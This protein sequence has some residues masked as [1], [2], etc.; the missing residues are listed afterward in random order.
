MIINQQFYSYRSC[1][2]IY[3][4]WIVSYIWSLNLVSFLF[5]DVQYILLFTSWQKFL[6]T[7]GFPPLICIDRFYLTFYWILYMFFIQCMIDGGFNLVI[8]LCSNN[9]CIWRYYGVLQLFCHLKVVCPSSSY[10]L[11]FFCIHSI[12]LDRLLFQRTTL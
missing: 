6:P 9:S 12:S 5:L 1:T 11:I 7:F 4:K 2:I 3:S 10:V 8:Y